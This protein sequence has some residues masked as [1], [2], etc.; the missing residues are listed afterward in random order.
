MFSGC[1]CPKYI[2]HPPGG[3]AEEEKLYRPGLR[4]RQIEE[5]YNEVF[6]A[7]KTAYYEGGVSSVYVWDLD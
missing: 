5:T 4:L 2:P 7:Y 3:A 6:D 1:S